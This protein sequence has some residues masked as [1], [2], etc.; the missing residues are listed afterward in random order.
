[1]IK[2]FASEKYFKFKFI[3][4]FYEN[5]NIIMHTFFNFPVFNNNLN[6]RQIVK[7]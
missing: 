2:K 5:N 7:F 3:L 4:K 1:M 6:K